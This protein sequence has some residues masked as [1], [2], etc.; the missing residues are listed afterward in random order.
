METTNS[1]KSI[2]VCLSGS[3][4]N[5]RVIHAAGRMAQASGQPLVGVFV[6]R[7]MESM[8]LQENISYAKSLNAMIYQADSG[9]VVLMIS[10]YARKMNVS[11]LFIGSSAPTGMFPAKRPF[12]QQ[13]AEVLPDID[14]HIIPDTKASPFPE[15]NLRM[16]RT[17][18]SMMDIILLV[19]IMSI[20]TLLSL[21][22][23]GSKYSNANIITIY[24]LAVL[25]TSVLTAHRRYGIIAALLYIL[26]FNFLFIDPRFTLLVYDSTY[27]VTYFVSV[28]AALITG[29][30]AVRMKNIAH[31]FAENAYQAKILLDTSSQL[32][33]ASDAPDIIR[34]T[35]RQLMQLIQRPILFYPC[36]NGEVGEPEVFS[37]S[38]VSISELTSDKEA[39]SW[40]MQNNQHSGAYTSHF[41]ACRFRY[42]NVH[43]SIESYGVIGV[44]MTDGP[45]REFENSILLSMITEC[46]MSLDTEKKEKER[47]EAEIRASNEHFRANLLRSISHD[48][49]TPLTSI[50]GHADN[51]LTDSE[52][53]SEEERKQ[54]YA[55]IHDESFWL[56][57]QME[58]I[59][60]MTRLESGNTLQMS[61][62]NVQDII[63]E[64][65]RH[66]DRHDAGHTI[67]VR[68]D[69]FLFVNCDIK[70]IIQ[71]LINLVNNAI[72]HTPDG[73][74][75]IIST[76]KEDGLVWISVAD[77]GDGIR[78]EDKDHIFE[79]FYSGE[80]SVSDSHRSL[81][82]GLNL[83]HTIMEKH[84]QQ[85]I[86]EDNHPKGTVFRISLEA[87]EVSI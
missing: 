43:S 86:V 27:L 23:Y 9:D 19:V 67:T 31:Q 35:C 44:D 11:D 66:V 50:Y 62:E 49:R 73:T 5:K 15:I 84:G 30:L 63:E 41:P 85:I 36:E 34:I 77:D 8:T 26:L 83:C 46:A 22:F 13:L 14:I 54:I 75:V 53:L 6:G 25:I 69:D 81:G 76:E 60:V 59:L 7:N 47:E 65:L 17:H 64:S 45:L 61:V 33:Q 78:A 32:Q 29:S 3:P 70:L 28:I 37:T 74:E 72:K 51:L 16:N 4:T 56:N 42:L 68:S 52:S 12:S 38:P 10:D 39:V 80:H 82:L 87:K 18:G 48:L 55:D 2:M 71:V 20:A 79:L 1:E 58:N 24:I 57:E 21:W 40:T